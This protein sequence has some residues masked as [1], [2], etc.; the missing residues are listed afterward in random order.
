[1]HSFFDAIRS[2]QRALATNAATSSFDSKVTT[3]TEPTNDGVIDLTAAGSNLFAPQKMKLWFIGAGSANDTFSVRVIGWHSIVKAGVQKTWFPTPIGEFAVT[4]GTATGVAGGA[5]LA[6]ELWADTVT[7]V[8]AKVP[9]RDIAAGT[10]VNSD[11]EFA[12]PADNTIAH[13][14][15]PIRGF[16]KI[17]FE[18]DQ[19]LNTPTMN[20]LYSLF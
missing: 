19:T 2:P 6:T 16:E 11:Y 18:F 3:L 9:D 4:L 8:A 5:V 15:M 17:E 14:R 13:V 10:A 20:V 1:M 12:S 7:P